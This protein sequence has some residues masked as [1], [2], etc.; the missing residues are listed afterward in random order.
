M[1]VKDLQAILSKVNPELDIYTS[2][3]D[4]CAI[5]WQLIGGHVEIVTTKKQFGD[6]ERASH[7]F[8][9]GFSFLHLY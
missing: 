1:K 5:I 6:G 3:P 2:D 7:D 8:P 4:R 9:I